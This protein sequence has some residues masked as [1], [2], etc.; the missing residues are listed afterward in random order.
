MG[1]YSYLMFHNAR[2]GK[3]VIGNPLRTNINRSLQ[4]CVKHGILTQQDIN[5]FNTATTDLEI[6]WPNAPITS[7]IA[8]DQPK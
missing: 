5:N 2:Q 7:P 3:V 6:Y 1:K 4:E 8:G